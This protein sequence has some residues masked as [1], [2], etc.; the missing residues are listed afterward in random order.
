MIN[1][2]ETIIHS[3]VVNAITAFDRQHKAMPV[4]VICILNIFILSSKAG[5]MGQHSAKTHHTKAIAC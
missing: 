1:I 4:I 5:G 2:I 3:I